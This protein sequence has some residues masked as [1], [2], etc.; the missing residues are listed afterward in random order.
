MILARPEAYPL[1]GRSRRRLERRLHRGV[2]LKAAGGSFLALHDEP[3]W[4][5]AEKLMKLGLVHFNRS[6]AWDLEHGPRRPGVLWLRRMAL[7]PTEFLGQIC[8][9]LPRGLVQGM[10]LPPEPLETPWLRRHCFQQW[11]CAAPTA[12]TADSAARALCEVICLQLVAAPPA[13]I[14]PGGLRSAVV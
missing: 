5:A 10:E 11:R 7:C 3:G 14:G 13:E 9:I 12:V 2:F 1:P 6:D 4:K 8:E